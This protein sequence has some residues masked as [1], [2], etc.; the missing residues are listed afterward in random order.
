MNDEKFQNIHGPLFEELFVI[1]REAR[2]DLMCAL[3]DYDQCKENS[4]G[5]FSFILVDLFQSI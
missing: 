5:A 4:T 3:Y 2:Y 1:A